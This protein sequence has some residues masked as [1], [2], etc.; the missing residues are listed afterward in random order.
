MKRT[1]ILLI[2]LIVTLLLNS[3]VVHIKEIG[4]I[5]SDPK[6]FICFSHICVRQAYGINKINQLRKSR[7]IKKRKRINKKHKG[8]N[9]S[10]GIVDSSIDSDSTITNNDS[11]NIYYGVNLSHTDTI[12]HIIFLNDS[13]TTFNQDI[14]M[15]QINIIGKEKIEKLEIQSYYETLNKS[16]KKKCNRQ[17]MSEIYNYLNKNA[18][19]SYTMKIN[20]QQETNLLIKRNLIELYITR[21][22]IKR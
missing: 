10:N 3:C 11:S 18:L 15:K 1:L 20:S 7:E 21:K 2:A 8:G 14:L 6:Q 4:Q 13:I 22:K 16:S 5:F 9:E 17:R 12:I 19:P